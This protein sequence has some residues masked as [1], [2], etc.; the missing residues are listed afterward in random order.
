MAKN[1]PSISVEVVLHKAI[2]TA[3]QEF[4]DECGIAVNS[5]SIEWINRPG[6]NPATPLLEKVS[7]L[8]TSKY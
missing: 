8:S 4:A 7:I 6:K 3:L 2:A 5:I 1:K